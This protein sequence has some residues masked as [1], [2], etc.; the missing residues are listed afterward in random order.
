MPTT[1]NDITL[2][3]HNIFKNNKTFQNDKFRHLK[4]YYFSKMSVF[5]FDM[6]L[7]LGIIFTH[8]NLLSNKS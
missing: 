2:C 6:Y 4:G 1:T 5:Y 7:I 8:F 3:K